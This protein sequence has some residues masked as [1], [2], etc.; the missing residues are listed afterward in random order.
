MLQ[1][2]AIFPSE[3]LVTFPALDT[4]LIICGDQAQMEVRRRTEHLFVEIYVCGHRF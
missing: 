3:T 4:A 1:M 2:A